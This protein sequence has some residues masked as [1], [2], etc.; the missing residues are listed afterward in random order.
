MKLQW[1]VKSHLSLRKAD[2]VSASL[3]RLSWPEID[4]HAEAEFSSDDLRRVYGAWSTWARN[5]AFDIAD[6]LPV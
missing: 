1:F 5:R 3:V 2:F 4:V 6:R